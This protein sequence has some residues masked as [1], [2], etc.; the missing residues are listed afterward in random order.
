MRLS[1]RDI[2]KIAP[3]PFVILIGMIGGALQG[4]LE[5]V[6]TSVAGGFAAILI[7]GAATAVLGW[8]TVRRRQHNVWSAAFQVVCAIGLS[9]LVA[10]ALIIPRA[11]PASVH[12]EW[13]D[14]AIN[15]LVPQLIL[16]PTRFVAAAVLVALGRMLPG[17]GRGRITA[18]GAAPPHL[19]PVT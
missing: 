2:E 14:V 8:I 18:P 12:L 13:R 16:S 5:F 9:Q 3:V 4:A 1:L 6:K 10:L 17:S 19:D 11:V 7:L 15:A